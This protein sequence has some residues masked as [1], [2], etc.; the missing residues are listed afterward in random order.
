MELPGLDSLA[1]LS[2]VLVFLGTL[3]L[4]YKKLVPASA[5]FIIDGAAGVGVFWE[6]WSR[7]TDHHMEVTAAFSGVA[8]SADQWALLAASAR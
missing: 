7:E 3:A 1:T 6:R 5:L 4:F 2:G 8:P